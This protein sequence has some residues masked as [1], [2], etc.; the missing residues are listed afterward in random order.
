V[1]RPSTHRLA[2]AG[3]VWLVV[4]LSVWGADHSRATE[5][6]G[7]TPAVC[8]AAGDAAVTVGYRAA[9]GGRSGPLQFEDATESWGTTAPLSGMRAHAVAT[10]DVDG[11]G[12]TDV[13]VGSFAD[14]PPEEYAL[15]GADG[16]APDRLLLGGKDGF[17]VDGSFP[18]ERARTSGAAFADLDADGDP[19]LVVARNVRAS[20]RGRAPTTVLRNDDGVLVPVTTLPEPAGA[21]SV[22]LLDYDADGL[23]DLFVAEDRFSGG[24]SVLLRNLG[25]FEFADVTRSSGIGNGVAGMGV[26]TGDLD[27]D[28][29]PDL[30]VGGSNRVFRNE[31]NGRFA[32]SSAAPAPWPVYGD[33]D[34]P[35]GVAQG[36]VNRDGRP[37]LV[38]GQHYNS[39]IDDGRQ[40]PVRLYLNELDDSGAMRFRDVTDAAGL[41]R[42]PTK[43]PHVDIA[44]VD[45]DGW[46]DI[47]TTAAGEHGQPVVFHNLGA[48][49]DPSFE[50]SSAPGPAQYWV[51][52]AVDDFD[53]DGRLDMVA[54]EWEPSLPT[55]FWRN[56][57]DVGH[58]IA[59]EAPT[60][61]TVDVFA[62]GAGARPQRKVATATVGTS[63]GYG[64]GPA[65]RVQVGLGASASADVELSRPGAAPVDVR[66]VRAD[67]ALVCSR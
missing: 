13:F 35:A 41:L 53:H 34:D 40:V 28:R 52:A 66:K 55:R 12:W 18:A 27:G 61:T 1:S 45:A 42:L 47:V 31:G 49:G 24:S 36:D 8:R 20:E 51:T 32:E 48:Q 11:D 43:S 37:D 26:A 7:R 65:G 14:R 60:G 16:P 15:R 58:W 57:G 3:A 4:G 44:D 21:R 46:P 10:A 63:T 62:T 2:L 50:A 22:G 59:V 30:F 6:A 25:N 9:V 54:V 33:E 56:T 38:V 23:L 67:R 19:D 5:P 29:R 17:R 39:T 64:A